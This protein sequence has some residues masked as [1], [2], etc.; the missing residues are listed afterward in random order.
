MSGVSGEPGDTL[1]LPMLSEDYAVRVPG[2][3]GVNTFYVGPYLSTRE[4]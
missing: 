4:T 2:T 3:F 1:S